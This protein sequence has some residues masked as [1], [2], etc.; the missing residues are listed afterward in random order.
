MQR[1]GQ[2]EIVHIFG[3]PER[4]PLLK[5]VDFSNVSRRSAIF[6]TNQAD[7]NLI[8]IIL[9]SMATMQRG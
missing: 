3:E 1:P 5:S 8:N 4:A 6:P 2:P 9:N 7:L